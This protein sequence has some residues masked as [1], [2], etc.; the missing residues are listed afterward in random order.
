MMRIAI[1]GAG[2][3]GSLFGGRLAAAGNAVTLIDVDVRHLAAIRASG[4]LLETDTGARRVAIDVA[5]PREAGGSP[6]LVI[7][8]T[9]AMH[10][11]AALDGVRHLLG[12]T[13]HV[14]SLQNGLGNREA[15][16]GF[17]PPERALI[18]VTTIPADF[19]VPGH[20]R[21]HGS[22]SI[23]LMSAGGNGRGGAERV[24]AT[25]SAAG[26]ETTVDPDVAIA[27]WEKV[28]FNAALNSVCAVSGCTVGEV[29]ALPDGRALALAIASE[30]V[31]VARAMGVDANPAHV[32]TTVNAA[33]DQHGAH[34][35]S[36]LQDVLAGRPTEIESIN[37]AVI[38]AARGAGIGAPHTATLLTLMRLL[39]SRRSNP[40]RHATEELPR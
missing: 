10:T 19:V 18:G 3:M 37:G 4:L 31:A 8:F 13:V 17:V 40:A 9:K 14:L 26:L 15:I 11:R 23:K 5:S 7:V 29:A 27:I 34:K 24:A 38:D 30:T 35:P 36:M 1:V 2:A 16:L 21:S 39:E 20:V 6:E 25:L 33:L 12:D 28:A 32:A 22:G